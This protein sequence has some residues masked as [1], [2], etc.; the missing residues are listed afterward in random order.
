MYQSTS[1]PFSCSTSVLTTVTSV[2]L[3]KYGV[4][5][6]SIQ[7]AAPGCAAL[8]T[9]RALLIVYIVMV[10]FSLSFS[11]FLWMRLHDTRHGWRNTRETGTRL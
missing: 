4:S 8:T 11:V 9:A 6:N 1:A 3:D 5:G 2:W 7:L 10:S